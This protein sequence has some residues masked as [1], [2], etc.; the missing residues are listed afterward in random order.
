MRGGRRLLLRHNRRHNRP[1]VAPTVCPSPP[2][3]PA[4][5]PIWML[6]R[7][8]Y[9]LQPSSVA[10]RPVLLLRSLVPSGGHKL[11]NVLLM[12]LENRPS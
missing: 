5:T 11:L 3:H 8:L 9:P 4:T 6:L 12:S 2:Y 1:F 10:T 7:S